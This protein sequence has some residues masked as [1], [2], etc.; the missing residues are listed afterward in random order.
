MKNKLIKTLAILSL[1]TASNIVFAEKSFNYNYIDVGYT[2]SDVKMAT[3][4]LNYDGYVVKGVKEVADNIHILGEYMNIERSTNTINLDFKTF[5]MGVHQPLSVDTDLVVDV[6]K[7]NWNNIASTADGDFNSGE[8][9]LRHNF[10]DDLELS[11]NYEKHNTTIGYDVFSIGAIQRVNNN[12]LIR[13]D[14]ASLNRSDSAVDWD[15]T[16]LSFRHY[17]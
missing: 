16:T 1:V 9:K 7:T 4:N 2:H 14:Y 10:S 5:G 6:Y 13:L 12:F 11:V 15:M 8:V 3:S 17:Y